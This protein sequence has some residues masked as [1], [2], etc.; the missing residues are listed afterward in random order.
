MLSNFDLIALCKHYKLP[1]K[2]IYLRDAL[3]KRPLPGLYILNQDDSNVNDGTSYGTHWVACVCTQ[4]ECVYFDSFACVP[5]PEID[6]WIKSVYSNYGYNSWICQD[7]RA[8][9]CGFWCVAFGI[10]CFH[11]HE[12]GLSLNEC[13]NGFINRFGESRNENLLREFFVKCGPLS[14]IVKSKLHL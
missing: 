7:I 9:T 10:Y 3:P 5:P 8:E 11:K 13:A 14:P 12:P 1:I 4:M 6:R 2:G